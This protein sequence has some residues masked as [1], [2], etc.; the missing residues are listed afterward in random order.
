MDL[1]VEHEFEFRVQPLGAVSSSCSLLLAVDLATA[2]LQG[3][4]PHSRENN[5]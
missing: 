5:E 4:G 2:L 3:T 1:I